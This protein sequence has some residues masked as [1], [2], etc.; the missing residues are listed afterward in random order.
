MTHM[1]SAGAQVNVRAP[2]GFF[3]YLQ[4]KQWAMLFIIAL[5]EVSSGRVERKY[6]AANAFITILRK[7][8]GKIDYVAI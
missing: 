2:T 6:F 3:T 7:N 5:P 4:V 1:E 8:D